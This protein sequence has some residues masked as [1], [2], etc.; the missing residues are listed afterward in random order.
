M[1]PSGMINNVSEYKS[2]DGDNID[3]SHPHGDLDRIIING[4]IMPLR[5]DNLNP[6][7]PTNWKKCLRGEDIAFLFEG[8]NE[9]IMAQYPSHT[10]RDTFYRAISRREVW[11]IASGLST[12]TNNH[13]LK[14]GQSPSGTVVLDYDSVYP[15]FYAN[16]P[17]IYITNADMGTSFDYRDYNT[18]DSLR[19]SVIETM[20]ADLALLYRFMFEFKPTVVGGDGGNQIMYN[21]FGQV[22]YA[23]SVSLTPPQSEY[24][25][26]VETT[27]ILLCSIGS[28][29]HE[30]SKWIF[31]PISTTSIPSPQDLTATLFGLVGIT[32]YTSSDDLCVATVDEVYAVGVISSRTRW[33]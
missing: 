11:Y 7:N 24:R 23:T 26:S 18:G 32:D 25:A 4:G 10:Y 2:V 6:L 29:K 28:L 27:A 21:G 33:T 9:R 1:T 14:T 19:A 16:Y 30:V 31:L 22:N 17:G 13:W 8:C 12:F 3:S 5:D 20:F 15:D